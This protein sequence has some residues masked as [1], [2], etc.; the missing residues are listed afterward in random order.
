M[1]KFKAKVNQLDTEKSRLEQ[2]LSD[3]K[4]GGDAEGDLKLV[5]LKNIKL[6]KELGKYKEN[7]PYRPVDG[8][9]QQQMHQIQ[10][11]LAKPAVVK[12]SVASIKNFD[13]Q[14]L[15]SEDLYKIQIRTNRTDSNTNKHDIEPTKAKTDVVVKNPSSGG[16]MKRPVPIMGV[17]NSVENFQIIP[18][19]IAETNNNVLQQPVLIK[20]STASTDAAKGK[21]TSESEANKIVAALAVAPT[22][23]SSSSSTKKK[24][25]SNNKIK[26][27]L[28]QGVPPAPLQ[29][30][31]EIEEQLDTNNYAKNNQPPKQERAGPNK[32]NQNPQNLFD[33]D[34][35][36]H[37]NGAHEDVHEDNNLVDIDKNNQINS[38]HH[39]KDVHNANNNNN[40]AA[41]EDLNLYNGN[42]VAPKPQMR[43]VDLK[44]RVNN[45]NSFLNNNK[46]EKLLK[47][48][49]GDHGKEYPDELEDDLPM[50]GQAEDQ[51][52]GEFLISKSCG[53]YD[54][55][56]VV[57]VGEYDDP[58]AQGVAERN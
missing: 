46:N 16:G 49:E 30:V 19:P 31:N 45:G 51:G 3:N 5:Q 6:E 14:V 50:D 12:S 29:S 24:V 7:C 17:L 34:T 35:D 36:E 44:G 37:E 54:H 57:T 41:E 42:D 11:P 48:I 25:Q 47:E 38:H 52:D 32:S 27:K 13:Q 8:D 4:N 1:S 2:L 40:N 26:L 18:K 43:F 58:K 23:S 22:Q 55:L 10:P 15:V 39:F 33:N 53:F 21:K 28:P 20:T 9:E 56:F